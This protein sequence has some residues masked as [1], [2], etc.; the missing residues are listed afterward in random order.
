[1]RTQPQMQVMLEEILGSKNVYFQP[2]ENIKINYPAIVYSRNR[3][4]NQHANDSVYWQSVSYTVTVIDKNPN[5]DIVFK[6]SRLLNC[7]HDRH[8]KSDN[9][10]H[11][12]FI[13][14]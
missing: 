1:M 2:P 6:L 3:I 9:L 5:S 13:L 8:F 10:N 12:V 14:Y 4:E 11:D 7:R